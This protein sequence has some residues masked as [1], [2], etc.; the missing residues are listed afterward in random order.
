[1]AM[2][3]ARDLAKSSPEV[4]ARDESFWATL[5]K[6]FTPDPQHTWF[7]C[8]AN[9]PAP[10]CVHA[11]FVENAGT[12]NSWPMAHLREV[13][14]QEKQAALRARLARLVNASA[15]EIA[16]LRNTTEALSNVIFGLD[17][18]KGDE[19][20]ITD[21]DYGS[22][23]DAWAQRERREG[24]VIRR[25]KTPVPAQTPEDLVAV[26]RRALTPRTRLVMFSH[27]SAV[28]G[29][30]FP[31]RAIAD[32]AHKAGAQVI[33]DGALSLGAIP[34]DVRAMDCDYFGA[35]LH[36]GVFAPTGTGFLYVRRER[37][38][39]L[40]PLF[41]A[42]EADADDI[43]KLEHRGTSPVAALATVVDAL[44]LHEAIGVERLAARYRYLKR[45]WADRMDAHRRCRLQVR[46]EPEHSCGIALMA[47][48][49][50]DPVKAYKYLYEKRAISV[51]PTRPWHEAPVGLW[52]SPY[53]FTS[54]PELEALTAAL[55][56][57]AEKGVPS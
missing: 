38:R 11:K 24:I 56:D 44:D 53:P 51:W 34:V 40:W 16:L 46:L 52:V 3:A 48:E 42:P 41:G 50:T 22:F 33:V 35:S 47:I 21:Q 15:E 5:R 8:F 19:V 36:K 28:T 12:V 4:A 23:L 32:V 25:V 26:V 13:F 49:G 10:S 57:I 43:R 31:A 37:I 2:S 9:N 39:S 1:M 27:I 30:I 20:V 54:L 14:G 45:A 7:N 17:L 18:A 6:A 29:Q 55:T